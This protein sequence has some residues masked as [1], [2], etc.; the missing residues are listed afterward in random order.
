M[1]LTTDA[2]DS[3][4]PGV[5]R[6]GKVTG[7]PYKI[8]DAHGLYLLV[9]PT[10][11]KWWRFRYRFFGKQNTV[12]CGVYPDVSLQQARKQRDSFR[13][14]LKEE[15]DPSQHA[16]AERAARLDEANRK[17]A[18]TRF[19]LDSDGALSFLLGNRCLT[20]TPNETGELRLFLDATRAVNPKV[21]PCP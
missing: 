6:D 12:S 7:R 8:G 1:P 9:S 11:G 13:A 17:L 18:A 15:V 4:Q 16:K 14:L 3:A 20:L 10:G 2:I 21:T 5:T 19:T